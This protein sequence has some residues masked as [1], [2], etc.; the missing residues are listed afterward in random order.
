[1]TAKFVLGSL[2]SNLL[3][4]SILMLR[5]LMAEKSSINFELPKM[6]PKHKNIFNNLAKVLMNLKK[7]ILFTVTI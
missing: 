1:M 7:G 5:S 4:S 3:S 2:L 6:Y